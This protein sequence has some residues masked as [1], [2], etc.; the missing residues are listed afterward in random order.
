M[1]V[2][3]LP[4]CRPGDTLCYLV[5]IAARQGVYSSY[6]Q[7]HIV[8]AQYFRDHARLSVYYAENHFLTVINGE[9]AETRN[10]TFKKNLASL[11]NFVMIR[12]TKEKTVVPSESSWFGAFAPP[13]DEDMP[14]EEW[15]VMPMEQQPLYK[16]DWIGLRTVR[17]TFPSLCCFSSPTTSSFFGN[18]WTN[19][20]D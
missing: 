16:E 10:A 13:D 18:S 1:G 3:D 17:P 7:E 9:V 6:A 4:A 11:A 14:G 8:Q 19:L 2:S 20:L 5:R 12:L 15:K